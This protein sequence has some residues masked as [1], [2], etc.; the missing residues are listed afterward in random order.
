MPQL[1]PKQ[2]SFSRLSCALRC[3]SS[4]LGS[5][6]G[7]GLPGRRS[8][9]ER[10][11]SS[12]PKG[13]PQLP[14]EVRLLR[15]GL[16]GS[17]SQP[18]GVH[19]AKPS[20]E[21]PTTSKEATIRVLIILGLSSLE[22]YRLCTLLGFPSVMYSRFRMPSGN[23]SL[24]GEGQYGWTCCDRAASD[25]TTCTKAC[26]VQRKRLAVQAYTTCTTRTY[27]SEGR[28]KCCSRDWVRPFDNP[29]SGA[30]KRLE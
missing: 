21:D 11:G 17:S 25:R 27:C 19:A 2:R 24:R 14:D 10:R 7:S 6:V 15:E 4:I 3:R 5:G 22:S 1:H 13:L 9:D 16:R 29:C 18:K 28:S 23:C 30:S 12:Q 26:G 8:S 20:C